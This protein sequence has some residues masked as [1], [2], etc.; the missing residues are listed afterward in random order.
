MNKPKIIL[1]VGVSSSGKSSWT[2][3]QMKSDIYLE[4]LNRDEVRFELFND[5]DRDWSKY[6]FNRANEKRVSDLIDA[7]AEVYSEDRNSIIISDTNL[8]PNIRLKWKEWANKNDYEYSEVLFPCKWEELV[9][10]N[11]QREGGISES[12]LWS[13][14]K[15]YMQQFGKIGD[16]D[17]EVYQE[18]HTL[19]HTIIVDID[20]TVADM[21]GIRKPFEWDKVLLDSPRHQIIDMVYGR[22]QGVGHVTFLSGRDGCCYDDTYAWIEMHIMDSTT[23]DISWDLYMRTPND[24]RKDDIVKYEL[25]KK[26]IRGKYNVDCLFDDRKQVLRMWSILDIPNIVDVGNYNEEF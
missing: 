6:K 19:P 4:E 7:R 22:A 11:S 8:N 5:G 1:T 10:R 3:E 23:D 14:Y 12:I 24:S 21:K 20:G 26:H 18:D 13:Q 2:Q 15:R 16:H 9:K 17:V 25:Y